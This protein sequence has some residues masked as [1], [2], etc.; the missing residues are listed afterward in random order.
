MGVQNNTTKK[1][2]ERD[3][4]LICLMDIEA[5][6]FMDKALENS[7]R[8]IQFSEKRERSLISRLVKGV[9]ERRITLDYVIDQFSKIKTAK[10]KS[11]I[12]NAL[13]LGVYQLFFMCRDDE[14]KVTAAEGDRSL[15]KSFESAFET[16]HSNG[17]PAS[18]AVNET[19]KLVRKHGFNSLAGFVNGVLRSIEREK[20]SI[21]YPDKS[22]RIKYLSVMYSTPEWLVK[23]ISDQYPDKAEQILS[24]NLSER[25]LSVR[26]NST[27]L[28]RQALISELESEGITAEAS[29][30]AKSALNISDVD[31]LMR[32]FSFREGH[33]TVQD[34]SSQAAVEA[35][36]IKEGDIVWDIC[37]APGG[38]TTAAAEHVKS[39]KGHVYS[40]DLSEEKLPLI[41]ENAERM[42]LDDRIT[43]LQHNA[44]EPYDNDMERPDVIIA[45]LPCSGL[46]IMPRKS[47]IRYRLTPESIDELIVLQHAILSNSVPYL[48][49]GGKLMFSTCTINH[50]E[51]EAG[52][53]YILKSFPELSLVTEHLFLQG[54]DACDGFYYSVFVKEK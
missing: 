13:R 49:P 16:A 47:D 19:V 30:Y 53:D 41:E 33:F 52:R 45:D 4:A 23:L 17:I 39:G 20:S 24:A 12:R 14:E 44:A 38:K 11:L 32:L 25:K 46:G 42:S 48:K 6:T 43:V 15:R 37:A 28:N 27:M 36:G 9:T 22:D 29:P 1:N 35:I 10:Q 54:V 34:A 18:A 40:M 5:G 31:F 50:G 21:A 3:I 8:R 7:L 26:V 51:N 2:N